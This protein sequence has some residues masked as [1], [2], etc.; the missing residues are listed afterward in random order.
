MLKDDDLDVAPVFMK[1]DRGE[2]PYGLTSSVTLS[3]LIIQ[4]LDDILETPCV[5]DRH[6]SEGKLG[7]IYDQF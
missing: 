6:F 2:R 5:L 7:W 3:V 4:E 1:G